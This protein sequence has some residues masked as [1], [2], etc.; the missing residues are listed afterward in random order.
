MKMI[1]VFLSR[2]AYTDVR[3]KVQGDLNEQNVGDA[4]KE[5]YAS[6]LKDIADIKT[7]SY[8]YRGFPLYTDYGGVFV[9]VV[10]ESEDRFLGRA[11][12]ASLGFQHDYMREGSWCG[13]LFI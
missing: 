5:M 7:S 13:V 6:D 10:P 1:A 8:R 12:A 9:C 4:I 3:A 11:V 2:E